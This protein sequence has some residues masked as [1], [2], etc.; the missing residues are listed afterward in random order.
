MDI[1]K[2]S[3]RDFPG[4]HVVR[5]LGFHCYGSILGW[6][7][8]IMQAVWHGKKKKKKNTTK[9]NYTGS[10]IKDKVKKNYLGGGILQQSSGQGSGFDPWLGNITC[11][12]M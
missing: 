1:S 12:V 9:F 4:G 10:Y 6:R 5:M 7:T 2:L 3:G 11:Y 8:E